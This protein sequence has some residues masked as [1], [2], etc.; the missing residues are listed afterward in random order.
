MPACTHTG[1][2]FSEKKPKTKTEIGTGGSRR[3]SAFSNMGGVWCSA[4]Y[5][6]LWTVHLQISWTELPLNYW[7]RD[8]TA[9]KLWLCLRLRGSPADQFISLDSETPWPQTASTSAQLSIHWLCKVRE[10]NVV[11]HTNDCWQHKGKAKNEFQNTTWTAFLHFSLSYFCSAQPCTF[12]F[13]S[14]CFWKSPHFLKVMWHFALGKKWK[15]KPPTREKCKLWKRLSATAKLFHSSPFTSKSC[16]PT[17]LLHS[18][19]CEYGE[20][21][22]ITFIRKTKK[23]HLN[24]R[25]CAESILGGIGWSLTKSSL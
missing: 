18:A 19:P 1:V 2:V 5:Y 13:S 20:Q 22:G 7:M 9:H 24:T 3:G 8:C 12:S 6:S 15:G 10:I 4:P 14:C 23:I 21:V 25:F 16:T 11:I 17:Q